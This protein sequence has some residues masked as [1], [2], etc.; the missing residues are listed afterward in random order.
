MNEELDAL[1]LNN[2]WEIVTLPQG[3]HAIGSKWVY[4]TKF[5]PDGTV[6]KYKARLVILGCHQKQGVDF[7]ETFAPVA[8]LTTVRTILDVASIQNWHTHQMDVSNAI[9]YGDLPEIVYMKLSKGYSGLGSRISVNMDLPQLHASLVCKLKKSLYG[10]RQAPRLW[11]SNLSSTLL[12][13][14]YQQSK[15]D[16]S[17]FSKHTSSSIT[18]ILVYVDDLVLCG[19]CMTSINALKSLIS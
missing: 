12:N 15:T 8:K 17:L 6:H 5:H 1:E 14:G 4:K 11:F 7:F 19:N 13:M 16:Y 10:L 9:L 3:K 18:L 2:T